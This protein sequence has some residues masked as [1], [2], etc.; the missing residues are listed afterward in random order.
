MS[1]L[2]SDI[3]IQTSGL[4]LTDAPIIPPIFQNGHTNGHTNTTS[5]D[6][7]SDLKEA[8]QILEEPSRLN[9]PI[10]IIV[11]GAG[12]SAINFARETDISPLDIEVCAFLFII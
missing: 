8:Y 12:A 3:D 9:H 11:I 6:R 2:P 10:K 4:Y 5:S 1:D 7:K